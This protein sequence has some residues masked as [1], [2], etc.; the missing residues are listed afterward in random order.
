MAA[1]DDGVAVTVTVTV[2]EY[3]SH[4]R[5]HTT[6]PPHTSHIHKPSVS[7]DRFARGCR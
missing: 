2:I 7:A 3:N 6:T 5:Y 4:Q 1:D